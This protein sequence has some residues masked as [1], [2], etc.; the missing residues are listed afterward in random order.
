MSEEYKNQHIVPQAYLNR[1]AVKQENSYIIGTRLNSNGRKSIKFFTNSVRNVAY[2][3]NYYDT[4]QQK[5]KKHWE[6][7]LDKNFDTLCGTPLGNIISTI[8]LS[9]E[10]SIVL[11]A[12]SKNILSRIIMSQAIRIPS[13]LNEQIEQSVNMLNSYK[14]EIIRNLTDIDDAKKELIEEI[15]FDSDTRKNIV[16]EGLF[17]EERFSRFCN[18]LEQKMWIVFYNGIRSQMPFVTSDNP[19]LFLDTKGKITKINKIGIANDD[20]VIFYPISPAILIGIYSPTSYFGA[21]QQYD[22]RKLIIDDE[23]FILKVNTELISQSHI[24]SFFPEPLFTDIK[25]LEESRN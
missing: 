19:V 24:H 2:I 22:C 20:A 25:K 3:E 23:K 18:A 8:T 14:K 11:T 5:D 16:L 10:K 15:S 21:M 4:L 6:H 7:Y 12:E 1:F 17:G 9:T 13:Y